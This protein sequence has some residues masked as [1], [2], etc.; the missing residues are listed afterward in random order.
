M[1]I[2]DRFQASCVRLRLIAGRF[3]VHIFT[4]KNIEK[5]ASQSMSHKSGKTGS[6]FFLSLTLIHAYAKRILSARNGLGTRAKSDQ[7][8]KEILPRK[9]DLHLCQKE[10]RLSP[11]RY[12]GWSL[13]AGSVKCSCSDDWAW[14]SES[15]QSTIW[16]WMA[17]AC[18][19]RMPCPHGKILIRETGPYCM[20]RV[21]R[22]ASAVDG[23]CSDPKEIWITWGSSRK[24]QWDGISLTGD[25]YQD[26]KSSP[27]ETAAASARD[28]AVRVTQWKYGHGKQSNGS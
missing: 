9:F 3:Q 11:A 25:E 27:G 14:A 28:S 21:Y 7:S 5:C 26:S 6:A 20:S 10:D 13:R 12:R 8:F 4:Q 1:Y 18:Q 16:A 23:S 17:V 22:I 2:Q 19:Q 15:T 24:N